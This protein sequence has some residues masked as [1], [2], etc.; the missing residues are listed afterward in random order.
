MK[1]PRGPADA[2]AALERW[3]PA[4]WT[5]SDLRILEP[6]LPAVRSWVQ[7]T[8]PRDAAKTRRLLLAA[9]GMAVWA[10]RSFG[11]VDP[12]V[13]FHPSNIEAWT[14]TVCSNKSIRWRETTRS[15]LRA[16]GRVVN[17]DGWPSPARK[18][19]RQPV[20]RPYM[21]VEERVFR[22]A[23][24]LP[25][26]VSRSQ[27]MWIICGSLGAGLRGVELAACRT[28]DI[29][30][31]DRGRLAVR[32]RG[33]H[34]RLVP[35]RTEYTD[36]AR[37][38]AGGSATDRPVFPD[39]GDVVHTTA[40]RMSPAL[41]FRRARSTWLVAHLTAGTPLGVLR[42]VAGPVALSTLDELLPFAADALDEQTTVLG[43]LGA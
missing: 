21:P 42:R 24:G 38:A 33:R 5:R 20:T 35:F 30:T 28:G 18:V 15:R 26:R 43:A 36:L 40:R 1:H 3:R 11:N 17:P 29:E 10:F 8:E 34:P 2:T 25:G 9:S 14:M 12:S 4:G 22:L 23:G 16:V 37:A 6:L 27:Q 39:G 31:L 32:V 7:Q 13:V 41:S 19:G